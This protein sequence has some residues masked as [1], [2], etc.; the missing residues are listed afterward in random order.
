MRQRRDSILGLAYEAGHV[1]VRQ[2]AGE[3]GVSEATVRR[4]LQTLAGEG[5]IELTYGGAS[6][7][8][9]C[10]YSFMSK[11]MRN[12]EAKKVIGRLAAELVS[13]GEQLF[14]DS[15]TTCYEMARFL[16]SKKGL[17]VIVNSVRTAQELDAPGLSVLM[18]GGQYRPARMD[19]VGPMTTAALERL[20]GYQ[21]FVGADGLAVDFGLTSVDI[22]SAHVFGLAVR[23]A[24][25]A[26]LVADHS[27][28][29]APSL[30][31]IVDWEAI[32]T[33]VTDTKPSQQWLDFLAGRGT[34]IVFP[35]D[36]P[37]PVSSSDGQNV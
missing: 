5:L 30:H 25:Q 8:R 21:A 14:V 26:V 28:F 7:V 24:R 37:L 6:V 27:K 35:E 3:L 19:T 13:D 23:N 1:S 33:V 17:S 11:A 34:K 31:K 22:E 12:V 36:S 4:D 32:S 18:L 9:N 20:R 16:R 10:D 29:D 2:L 15:G